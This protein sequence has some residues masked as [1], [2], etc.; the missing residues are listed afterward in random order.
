MSFN[1]IKFYSA[2]IGCFSSIENAKVFVQELKGN[3]IS[4]YIVKM[5]DKYKVYS[6]MFIDREDAQT[7]KDQVKEIYE[8]VFVRTNIIEGSVVKYA[9]EDDESVRAFIDIVDSMTSYY[10]VESQNIKE[11]K[12]SIDT[13]N[14]EINKKIKNLEINFVKNKELNTIKTKIIKN[15]ENRKELLNSEN[16]VIDVYNQYN[17]CMVEY[18]NIIKLN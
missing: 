12:N 7:H 5:D 13:N 11:V 15:I 2:Q 18:F 4:G 9:K 3:D 17:K 1:N 10:K 16:D 6:G 8:D 14:E